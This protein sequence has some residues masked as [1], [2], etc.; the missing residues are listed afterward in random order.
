M[1]ETIFTRMTQ[2][3]E[4]QDTL[5]HLSR[6]DLLAGHGITELHVLQRIGKTESITVT[7][8]AKALHLTKGAVSKTVKKLA[9]QGYIRPYMR[10]GNRQKI[11]FHLTDAGQELFEAH[12]EQDRIWLERNRRFLRGLSPAEREN[13]ADYLRRYNDYLEEEI[14]RMTPPNGDGEPTEPDGSA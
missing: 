13:A 14:R 2:F 8:L 6:N 11:Y 5:Y 1:E 9:G 3:L 12:E 10:E 4:K 7:E